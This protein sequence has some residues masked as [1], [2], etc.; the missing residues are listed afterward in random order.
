VT[1]TAARYDRIAAGYARWWAPVLAPRA[2]AL[3]DWLEPAV[4]GGARRL[5][6]IGTGG[7][8]L[9]IAAIRR[10]PS[11]QIV[12]IDASS[13]MAELAE[14]EADRLLS[15]ADRARFEVRVGFADEMPFEPGAFDTA[16]SSFVF[17]LVP[18]RAR[19]LRE[20][21]RVVRSGGLLAYVTWLR[22]SRVFQPDVEF[23]AV[24]DELGVEGFDDDGDDADCGGRRGDVPSVE[25]AAAQLRRAGFR[26][27]RAEA[28]TLEHAFDVEDYVRFMA[29]FDEEDLVSGLE[30]DLRRQLIDRLRSRLSALPRDSLVLKL[31]VVAA[32]GRR[33]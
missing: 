12:G 2:T 24:L 1:E 25:A 9:A 33:G 18:N 21:R 20:A 15:P 31:P 10:W 30:D 22:D 16:M 13:G 14:A 7:G 26:D 32:A 23:D 17:Q 29:E 4:A 11:V 19:A 6:D 3:L 28:A 27:V 8:T 5:L